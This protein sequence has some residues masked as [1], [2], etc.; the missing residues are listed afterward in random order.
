MRKSARRVAL[1]HT[2]HGRRPRCNK[3]IGPSMLGRF[4]AADRE[5]FVDAAI[6]QHCDGVV[7]VHL[8]DGKGSVPN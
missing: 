4:E 3:K 5:A 6:P 7:G 8:K 1:S 2:K